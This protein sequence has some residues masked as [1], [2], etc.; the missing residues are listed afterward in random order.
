MLYAAARYKEKIIAA[1]DYGVILISSDEGRSWNCSN[2]SES[3]FYSAALS[4][5]AALVGGSRGS[6]WRY[7]N[8]EWKAVEA[9]TG[10]QTV[11]ALLLDEV[12]K[13]GFAAGGKETGE[14]PFILHTQD[15]GKSW[16]P[17]SIAAKGRIAALAKGRDAVFAATMDGRIFTRRRTA[18]TIN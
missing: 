17:E 5:G 15:G 6:L 12:G 14:Q 4:N 16:S 1:G 18:Q 11:F 13:E 3:P 9:L 7:S 10:E 2:V 8:E